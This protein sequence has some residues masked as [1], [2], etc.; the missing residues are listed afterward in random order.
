MA[1][2]CVR[3]ID[4]IEPWPEHGGVYVARMPATNLVK[5][6]KANN[7]RRRL[8]D[9]LCGFPHPYEL[10]CVVPGGIGEESKLHRQFDKQRRRNG[11]GTEWF[12]LSPELL[13]FIASVRA[14]RYPIRAELE[15][16]S[17][18]PSAP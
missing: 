9:L 6:G 8:C 16:V 2:Q 1:H 17:P 14:G 3:R 11:S 10:L 18:A 5:I 12:E 13:D 15:S 4:P 7:V